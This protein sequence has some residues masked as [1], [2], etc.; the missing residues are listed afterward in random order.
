MYIL[1]TFADGLISYRKIWADENVQ[2][3]D[4]IRVPRGVNNYLY[5]ANIILLVEGN[6]FKNLPQKIYFKMCLTLNN[7]CLINLCVKYFFIKKNFF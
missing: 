6:L 1:Y 5:Y 3:G 7:D 2:A 4:I